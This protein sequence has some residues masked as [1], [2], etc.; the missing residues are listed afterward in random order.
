[1]KRNKMKKLLKMPDETSKQYEVGFGKPPVEG[2]Y[3]P[4]VSDNLNGRP[5][6]SKNKK[7]GEG[8]LYRTRDMILEESNREVNVTE[9]GEQTSMPIMRLIMRSMAAKAA[10]G[11]IKA[12]ALFITICKAAA[13]QNIEETQSLFDSVLGYKDAW[14]KEAARRKMKGIKTPMPRPRAQDID[15]DLFGNVTI[16]GP[17]QHEELVHVHRLENMNLSWEAEL[18]CAQKDYDDEQDPK[19]K[20]SLRKTVANA[21]KMIET[22]SGFLDRWQNRVIRAC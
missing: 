9:R 14:Y 20:R 2:R 7:D 6:G 18:K 22:L 1:M 21:T 15:C 4:G 16:R 11:D 13:D 17:L 5:R 10:K 19:R 3:P 8:M 12:Q